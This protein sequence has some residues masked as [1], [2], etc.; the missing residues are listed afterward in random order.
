MARINGTLRKT[1]KTALDNQPNNINDLDSTSNPAL[2]TNTL[3]SS[4]QVK[5]LGG[6]GLGSQIIQGTT[7]QAPIVQ[8]AIKAQ[9]ITQPPLTQAPAVQPQAR[10]TAT[11]TTETVKVAPL[12]QEPSK[13]QAVPVEAVTPEADPIKNEKALQAEK[14]VADLSTFARDSLLAT[15]DPISKARFNQ[16]L[17]S[18]G[19]FN[20]AQSQLLQQQ[21]N[22]DPS[23][24]GQPTG[25]ALLSMLARQQGADVSSLITSLSI[26]SANRVRDLNTWGFDR[27]TKITKDRETDK[28]NIRAELLNAG[29][30]EGYAAQ[31]KADT[32]IDI[33]VTNMRELSPATQNAILTQETLLNAA[34]V[35]GDLEQAKQHFDTII[36]MAP[37]AFKGATFESMGFED[38]SYLLGSEQDE[39]IA[40]QVRLNL[41]QVPPDV[42]NAVQG[43]ELQFN[44]EERTQG[45]KDLFQDKT[46]DEI[47]EALTAAGLDTITDKTELIGRE[48]ELFTAFKIN[49][50]LKASSKTVVD[51]TFD[52]L[53]D[54]LQKQFEGVLLDDVD[55]QLIRGMADDLVTGGFFDVDADGNVTVD[56]NELVKPWEDG[57]ATENEFKSWPVM[58]AE[59]NIISGSEFYTKSNPP[60]APD[61]AMG[62]VEADLDKKWTNYKLNTPKDDWVSMTDWYRATKGGTTGFD[63]TII[64]K[65][66]SNEFDVLRL[67]E[68]ET[69]KT[70]LTL[71]NETEINSK[72]KN[73][74]S[75]RADLLD[76]A[77]PFSST[78]EFSALSLNTIKSDINNGETNGFIKVGNTLFRFSPDITEAFKTEDGKDIQVT[79][80]S[81][82]DS[83]G[84]QFFYPFS[85]ILSGPMKGSIIDNRKRLTAKAKGTT[86]PISEQ[87]ISVE[88]LKTLD[89][90]SIKDFLKNLDKEAT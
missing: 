44:L 74:P 55:L 66:N 17:S 38:Q 26:E 60:P 7:G 63:E 53:V 49:D 28:D 20:Q 8:P 48:D 21:I 3:Q 24:A 11:T 64:P 35:S 86:I 19:L 82:F 54:N 71:M 90:D 18:I 37:N 81:V 13:K 84:K 80:L 70:G 72:I 45:G 58:D 68:L 22:N 51:D 10:S 56:P 62:K 32:G 14:D 77:L 6:G 36:A 43:I 47:N 9:P 4:T 85:L 75:F 87:L 5:P 67:A 59:G 50:I 15:D 42:E 39:S 76:I 88:E 73:N 89:V 61:S 1:L 52:F 79:S 16:A 2:E 34:L 40:R 12:K 25:T 57:S 46:I 23:L 83:S 65:G 69:F 33:D 30:F 31:F 41:N 78:Q 29:D 27:L